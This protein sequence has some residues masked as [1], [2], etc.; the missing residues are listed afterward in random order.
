MLKPHRV[1]RS[2]YCFRFPTL[3]FTGKALELCKCLNLTLT[4]IFPPGAIKVILNGATA[5]MFP[6]LE[7]QAKYSAESD[8]KY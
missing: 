6:R 2:N 8:V 5:A 4:Q 3:T 7:M 1:P